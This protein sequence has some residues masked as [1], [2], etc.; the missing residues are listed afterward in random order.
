[1]GVVW[2][3]RQPWLIRRNVH[4]TFP[5]PAL[6]VL[7]NDDA[8]CERLLMS[9]PDHLHPEIGVVQ[10]QL[11][12]IRIRTLYDSLAMVPTPIWK[13]TASNYGTN[14]TINN[15]RNND[16]AKKSTGNINSNIAASAAPFVT[17]CGRLAQVHTASRQPNYGA[18]TKPA[19]TKLNRGVSPVFVEGAV[20]NGNP[21]SVFPARGKTVFINHTFVRMQPNEERKKPTSASVAVEAPKKD[22][23]QEHVNFSQS[24]HEL[25]IHPIAQQTPKHSPKQPKVGSRHRYACKALVNIVDV[26]SDPFVLCLQD[27]SSS[28]LLVVGHSSLAENDR[29]ND[30]VRQAD[31]S[32]D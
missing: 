10:T 2:M 17:F 27:I 25:R 13:V 11:H 29:V 22:K 20:P 8:Y 24:K 5:E 30:F 32:I 21:T 4:I 23:V 28:V 26:G 15:Q 12:C 16:S 18:A 7:V 19:Y 9:V 6:R 14:T 31:K 1:M 3:S